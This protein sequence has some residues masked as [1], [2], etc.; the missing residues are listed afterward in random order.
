MDPKLPSY[1]S[2][3]TA[4]PQAQFPPELVAA[5]PQ[6]LGFGAP[7][8]AFPGGTTGIRIRPGMTRPQGGVPAL[9]LPPNTL[10]LQLQQR[11]QG[12]QQVGGVALCSL[13]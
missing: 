8:G 5:G 7:R 2:Q 13:S 6:G 12:P 9:R 3:F 1:P 11:L 4:A 10:R